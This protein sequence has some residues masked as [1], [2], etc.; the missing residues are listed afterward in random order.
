MATQRTVRATLLL[1]SACLAVT[2]IVWSGGRADVLADSS[3]SVG[4]VLSI[5]A[6]PAGGADLCEFPGGPSPLNLTA[7]SPQ[8]GRQGAVTVG[9]GSN[10]ALT[11]DLAKRPPLRTITDPY[12][13]FAGVAV[14][15]V[16]NEV[17]L[18]DENVSALIVYD[19]LT[20]TPPNVARSQPKRAIEGDKTF[21]E[22]ASSVYIDPDN[23]DIYGIHNDTENWMP[24]FGR[25]ANGNVAPKGALAT[26]HTTAGI[27]ADE[28]ER[29][30][31]MTI[32]DDSAVVVFDKYARHPGPPV[33][34]FGRARGSVP[35]PGPK[36]I[37]QGSRTGLADPH[38]IALD[39]KKGEIFV[40]NW[41]LGNE[42]PPLTEQGGGGVGND[43]PDFPVGR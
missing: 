18:A 13:A 9:T 3:S 28:A 38:G 31:F 7:A 26:P 6:L 14:D 4:H 12:Y 37:L 5:Q 43:R 29:E 1:T 34:G 16:R 25:D 2:T 33:E 21:V 42:R 15:P 35:P 11:A 23:G 20:N 40:V 36:R 39:P 22:Y 27:A 32:Q 10:D 8:Q 19:R 24:V 17:V 41:G 30:L